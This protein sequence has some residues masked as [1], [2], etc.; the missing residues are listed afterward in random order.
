MCG[1]NGVQRC[2][3]QNKLQ[4]WRDNFTMEDAMLELRSDLRDKRWT[5]GIL[6]SGGLLDT[7]S[8]VRSG[9][10]PIWGCETNSTQARMWGKFTD[11]PN[12]GDVFGTKV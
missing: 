3:I 4:S 2:T 12:Y 5:V 6:F 8:A 10:T 11:T 9:F 7:F 1:S